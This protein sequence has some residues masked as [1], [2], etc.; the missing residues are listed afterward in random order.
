MLVNSASFGFTVDGGMTN[1][2]SE[3]TMEC[4]DGA[5]M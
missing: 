4:H 5:Q 1:Y 3:L 2:F